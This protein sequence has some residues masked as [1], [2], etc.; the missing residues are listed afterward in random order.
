MV[1]VSVSKPAVSSESPCETSSLF[2]VCGWD[3]EG[4]QGGVT[5]EGRSGGPCGPEQS[6][7]WTVGVGVPWWLSRSRGVDA[8]RILSLRGRNQGAR[9][10]V[11]G[12]GSPELRPDCVPRGGVSRGKGGSSSSFP[13]G[14]GP[15]RQHGHGALPAPQLRRG[16]ARLSARRMGRAGTRAGTWPRARE[17]LPRVV[18]SEEPGRQTGGLGVQYGTP[19][20]GDKEKGS[21]F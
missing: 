16:G 20:L 14:F 15:G 6:P 8:A 13:S 4:D 10:E 18:L 7:L 1:S 11:M 12:T 19:G 17:G 9:G 21:E 2:K 5:R 3:P